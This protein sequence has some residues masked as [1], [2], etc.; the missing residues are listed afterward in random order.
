MPV[1]LSSSRD[2]FDCPTWAVWKAALNKRV[3]AKHRY[4]GDDGLTYFIWF[5]DDTEV[6]TFSLWQGEVPEGVIISGY[7]QE[8]NDSDKADF[9]ANYKN[10]ANLP[11]A[12]LNYDG[13][14]I[15][16]PVTVSAG[17][18]H[19]WHG[20]GDSTTT[21][22]AGT[23]FFASN[24]GT[25]GDSATT[26]F[27]RDPAWIA[28]GTF[29]YTNAQLGDWV[30]FTIYAPATQIIPSETNT[31]NCNLI[32]GVLIPAAGDGAYDIDFT[33]AFPIPL[34]SGTGG[35]W[36]YAFPSTMMGRGTLS[37]SVP[38]EGGYHL[39]PARYNLDGFVRD[40][41]LLGSGEVYYEPQ[42]INVS[43]C[44]PGWEFECLLHNESGSHTLQA[45][46]RVLVT[47]YWTTI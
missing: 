40:E 30:R 29:K 4:N 46:W 9:E 34:P 28:G 23:Q 5:Y 27:Y 7:T 11:I 21:L 22:G 12:A 3:G 37:P 39:I 26:W 31:G 35:Y 18:W 42:N 43:L 32:Y 16:Q 1:S 10:S 45:V 15:T 33:N 19:Y 44:F 24:D 38:G 36:N 25:S 47:R 41:M 6:Y 20:V 13:R 17:Q 14:Q 8:Q 2:R